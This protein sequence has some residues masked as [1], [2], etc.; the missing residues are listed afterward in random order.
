MMFVRNLHAHNRRGVVLSWASIQT[1]A[2]I[3]HV[4][5]H[6]K[7]YLRGIFASLGYTYNASATR[8]L[9]HAAQFAWLRSRN[10]VVFN[11]ATYDL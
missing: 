1:S 4:N 9:R 6:S 7:N 10:L 11:R 3:G 8:T 2:G 5:L